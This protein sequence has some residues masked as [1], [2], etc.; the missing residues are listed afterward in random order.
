MTNQQPAETAGDGKAAFFTL[1]LERIK[2]VL[3]VAGPIAGASAV[4]TALA[5][6]VGYLAAKQHDQTL[7]IISTTSYSHYVRTGVEFVPRSLAAIGIYVSMTMTYV[8]LLAL[9]TLIF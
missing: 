1:A 7:G 5:F 2:Q 9:V 4:F 3:E 6:G 8:G